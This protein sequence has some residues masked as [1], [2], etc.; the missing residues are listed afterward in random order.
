MAMHGKF[1]A[2]ITADTLIWYLVSGGKYILDSFDLL[3]NT[4]TINEL[5]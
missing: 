1:E 3:H 5:T 4:V 2:M